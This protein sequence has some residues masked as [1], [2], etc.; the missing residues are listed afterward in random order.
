MPPPASGPLLAPSGTSVYVFLEYS[1]TS[2][3]ERSS[4]RNDLGDNSLRNLQYRVPRRLERAKEGDERAQHTEP[5]RVVERRDSVDELLDHRR[6]G[7]VRARAGAGAGADVRGEAL[8][9]EEGAEED[10]GVHLVDA[11]PAAERVDELLVRVLDADDHAVGE[12]DRARVDLLLR[13]V[14]RRAERLGGVLELLDARLEGLHELL[15][16]GAF[17]VAGEV[18][19]E[20]LVCSAGSNVLSNVH[21]ATEN[22]EDVHIYEIGAF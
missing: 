7:A 13:R 2:V 17:E 22:A 18:V 20:G 21:I 9:V 10:E 5:L 6:R 12:R 1:E 14:G 8:V 19:V 15:E 4:V 3:H 11:E 16:C